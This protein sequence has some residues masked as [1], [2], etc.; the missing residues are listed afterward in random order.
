MAGIDAGASRQP[1]DSV[2]PAARSVAPRQSVQ[3]GRFA[4]WHQEASPPGEEDSWLITYLDVMTLLLVMMV[5]MLAFSEPASK[6]PKPAAIAKLEDSD[7]RFTRI[8]ATYICQ[9][10]DDVYQE[11]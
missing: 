6:T 1:G 3:G 9:V 5:V 7:G 4:R 8:S 2:V 11:L 10:A